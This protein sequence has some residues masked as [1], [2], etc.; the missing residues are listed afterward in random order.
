MMTRRISNRPEGVTGMSFS[1]PYL[2][3]VLFTILSISGSLCA[4]STTPQTAKV[5]QGSISGRV[6]IKDK[7]APGVAIGLR[8]G[9]V[10]TLGEGFQRAT[11]DQDGFYRISNLA[12]GS[13]SIVICAPAFVAPEARDLSKQKSVLVAEGENVEG[14]DF[15]LIRGGV[16][17]G[18]VT[19]ADERPV[20]DQ[21]V[22]VY[23]AEMFDQKVQRSVYA[24]GSVQTDDRGIYRVFGLA[25]GRYKVAVGRSDN[26]L[27]VTY[28]QN[29]NVFYKQV[30]HPDVSDQSKATVVEVS[31]GGEANNIDITVGR[32]LQTFSASGILIDEHSQ[33]VPNLRFGFQRQLGQRLEYMN[34]SAI[35]NSRG[36]FIG[37]GLA[38]GHYVV[39]MFG[40]PTS[41][42]RPIEPFT[43]DIVDHDV[44]G[45]VVKLTRGVS[46]SGIV[47]L[48]NNDQAVFTKLLQLQLRAYGVISVGNG[49]TL[50]QS[51]ISPLGADGSFR[52]TGLP[53]G[54]INMLFA[55]PGAPLP[56]KGFTITRIERDGVVS[57]RG[58]EVKDGDQLIGV[59]VF[60]S[61]GSATLRG[62]VTIENGTLPQKG[63]IFARLTK[64]GNPNLNLRPM[65][66]DERGHFL[67]EGVPGGTY[68]LLMFLNLPGQSPRNIKREVTLQD[69]QTLDM[70]INVDLNEP[71]K[72]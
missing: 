25:P 14:I 56:P 45:L 59:R 5:P 47:V 11:T 17:T 35:A 21:Q 64:Q 3:A 1:A 18:R 30:F 67:M 55:T 7:G 54:N 40:S 39:F 8:K 23:Q 20:I 41:E 37:E 72:P 71:Q 22:N 26:E 60:V 36:E 68:D 58:L 49:A 52:L 51:A 32:T 62:V 9:D 66:V 43:F 24:V 69:G 42:L 63:R 48:E 16:I 10:Y 12:P 2:S 65:A 33:P 27:N 38:P 57:P 28:N 13:Y 70:T 61:Y 29:R 50:A 15:S 46:I 19:D 44:T 53:A 4:Q 34:N 31:E 6:T